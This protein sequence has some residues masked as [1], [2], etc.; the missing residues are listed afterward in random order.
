MTVWW[1]AYPL[2]GIFGGFVAGLFGVGGG[3]TLVPFMYMLF[4]AQHFPPEHVMHL[5]L[6][7]SM[8][9]IVFTS[10]SSMRAH[11]AHGAVRWDIVRT[12]APGLVLGTFGGSQLAGMVPTVPMTAIFVIIVYYASAQMILDFKPQ[13]HRQLPGPTGLFGVGGAIGVVSS[14]V[15]AGGGFLSIP[16]MLF[17]N[18]AIHVAVGTSSALGF[19]IALAGA[20]GY[21]VAGWQDAGLPGYTLGY[22]YLPAFFGV[23]VMSISMAPLGARLAHRLPVKKLKRAFGGFLALLASKMLYSLLG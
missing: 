11:H 4:V 19:P 12:L 18:V 8:A 14:M 21:I 1:L 3:L 10:I 23:V 15:A 22:I 2:L 17:C 20:L 16:F 9:T 6:G 7:T 5:A 13:A